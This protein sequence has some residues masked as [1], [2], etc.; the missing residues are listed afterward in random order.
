MADAMRFR[1]LGVAGPRIGVVGLG[2]WS[3]G[4]AWRMGWGEQDDDASIAAIEA[5]VDAGVDWLDTAPVYGLGA[6]E[7]LLR[8]PLARHPHVRVFSKVGFVGDSGV[9]LSPSA[10]R[11]QCEESLARLGRDR[12]DLLQLH[13]PDEA[14]PI[15]ETWS[16]MCALRDEGLVAALGIS[17]H[18]LADIERAHRAGRV[19]ALQVRYSLLDRRAEDDL[20][21]W[22]RA[23][24]V[25]VLAYSPLAS[26][27][28]G[29]RFDPARL[30]PDDWRRT[31]ERFL[32]EAGT[33]PVV[34]EAL[35]ELVGS[36]GIATAAIA[37]TLETPGV[38]AAIGGVRGASDVP[39]LVRAA[40]H[41][42]DSSTLRELDDL[43]RS[44]ARADRVGRR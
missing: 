5:A 2:T 20:I 32:R 4:G 10:V 28:L 16:A 22:A 1:R 3:M 25:G 30:A 42:W 34:I 19:D 24:G 14:V 11:R 33:A 29:G 15:D 17:N 18:G 6:A 31:D 21:P 12:L 8:A 43:T 37:W 39:A 41:A 26:G 13:W 36:D 38:T 9:D 44:S 40:R 23:E 7:R 35:R 27:L